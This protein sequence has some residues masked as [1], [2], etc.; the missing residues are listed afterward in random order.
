MEDKDKESTQPAAVTP[1]TDESAPDKKVTIAAAAAAATAVAAAAGVTP[2]SSA[3]FGDVAP[4][5][6]DVLVD[7]E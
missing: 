2:A 1:S 5:T 7:M 3:V 4:S 6:G